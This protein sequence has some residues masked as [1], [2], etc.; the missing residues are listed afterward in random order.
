MGAGSVLAVFDRG[1]GTVTRTK[2][3][4][5]K[6]PGDASGGAGLWR[7]VGHARTMPSRICRAYSNTSAPGSDVPLEASALAMAAHLSLQRM[8]G[9]ATP[10][11]T[12]RRLPC[13]ANSRK[14]RALHR[15]PLISKAMSTT[16]CGQQR[17]HATAGH[18][19]GEQEG[20]CAH[21]RI[22]PG[23]AAARR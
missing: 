6:Q 4:F 9:L 16:D 12:S 5:Q 18:R 3:N 15:P 2:D 19:R 20:G 21:V 1:A 17:A 22:V 11:M 14:T 23:S 8:A 10:K 13:G 7:L